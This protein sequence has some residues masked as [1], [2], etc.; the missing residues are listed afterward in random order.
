MKVFKTV[1]L[2]MTPEE[3]QALK[4]VYRMLYDLVWEDEQALANELNYNDLEPIRADLANLYE[5]GGGNA[6]TDL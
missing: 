1:E 5:L 2:E 4:T 3:K 6:D